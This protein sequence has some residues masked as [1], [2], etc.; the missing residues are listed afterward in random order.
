[1]RFS[2]R[3]STAVAAAGL[4]VGA[5]LTGLAPAA[6]A[7]AGTTAAFTKAAEWGGGYEGRFTIT[8]GGSAPLTSWQVDFD[9]PPGTSLGAYWDALIT[10]DGN[11]YRATSREY[12]GT[13]AAG[14]SVSFGFVATGSGAPLNCTVNG[15][16][17]TGGGGDTEAP[18][19]PGGLRVTAT[20][21]T[22]VSLAWNASTDNVG[23]AGYDVYR[24]D[25]VVTSATG[26][27]VTV[28]GLAPATEYSF[29]VKARDG[30]GNV[31]AASSPVAATTQPGDPGQAS[32]AAAPYLY[33]G[34][35][36]PPNATQV[37]SA[38]GIRWFT[39]AFI[40]SDGGCNPAWDGNRPLTGSDATR[41]SEIRAAGGDVIPSIGGWAGR[42]LGETCT[43]AT[44]LA[45]AYQKVIDAYR[46]KAIDIDIE[47]T[48]VENPAVR[49]RVVDALKI[50][51][52]KN[53]GIKEY[54][55]F[56][57]FQSGPSA[58]GNDLI[59]KAAAAGLAVDGFVIMPFNFNGP[60]D[61]GQAS[62]KAAE[63]LK[64][65][66]KSAYRITD[67]AAYRII[68]ISSMN[69]K[70]DQN[71]TVTPDHYRA[72]LG[73]AQQHHIARFTFWAL[74]RDR[75]CTGGDPDACSGIPQQQWEFTKITAQ[76][77]G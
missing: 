33:Y 47:N 50:V 71:E 31:S 36:S 60:A 49:Q 25:T 27:S 3:L 72:M 11:H 65:K 67:D 38:T 48:E 62:I 39:L 58:A 68:G 61:M 63:A 18:S 34:W 35:G 75:P 28:G 9:L 45:A 24:G 32:M 7:A 6:N 19:A 52:Q 41:I 54:L 42:K 15:G 21:S 70:T 77:T 2:R 40:L 23:V 74:N 73:Y 30:A 8:N 69:G 37:M 64:N 4:L 26:T 56:G 76:Y 46:L 29:S 12:N 55:T 5:A 10:P 66:V 20:T 43:D 22:T 14:A 53:P 13:V 16:S 57:T 44:S 1:M 59:D 17:C 51:K